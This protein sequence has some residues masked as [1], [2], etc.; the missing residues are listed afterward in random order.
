MLPAEGAA[1]GLTVQSEWGW[2]HTWHMLLCK[3]DGGDVGARLGGTV[4]HSTGPVLKVLSLNVH[5]TGALDGQ[6]QA[7]VA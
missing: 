1:P 3:P 4:T 2:G 7:T 6:G 5:L